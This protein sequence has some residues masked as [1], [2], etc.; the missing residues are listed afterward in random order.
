MIPRTIDGVSIPCVSLS[1]NQSLIP[2]SNATMEVLKDDALP[3]RSF[4]EISTPNGVTE[5]YRTRQPQESYTS[6]YSTIQ[7][8]HAICE[9]GDFLIQD[10]IEEEMTVHDAIVAVFNHYR[11]DK[12]QLGTFTAA[13]TVTLDCDYDN[14]LE[15]M[16]SILEQ[17]PKYYLTFDFSTSPWTVSVT[18]KSE[19]VT[20]EGRMSRNIANDTVKT[21]DKDQC[22]RVYV[23]GLP[24][25]SGREEDENAIGYM[26]ADAATIAQYG[27]IEKETGSGNLT[28]EQATRIAQAYL[29]AHKLPKRSIEID[30]DD[31]SEITG[32]S[33][34]SFVCGKKFRLA[35]PEDNLIIEDYITKVSFQD[36][37]N[38][39]VANVI[40]G[41]E[42][43]AAINFF[44]AQAS[45]TK[46]S[47][48]AKKKQ[49]KLDEAF[50]KSFAKVDETGAILE[51]A[52]MKL[53]SH[54]MIVYARDN[55]NNIGSILD[56]T[57]SEIRSEVAAGDL[58]LRSEIS[59]TASAIR[60]SVDNSLSDVHSNIIQTADQI[61]SEVNTSN[62]SVYS[63]INQ[64]ATYIQAVVSDVNNDLHSEILQTQS[65]IRSAV[66]T[67][68]SLV[69]S[70]VDQ[71]ASYIL[72]H[73]GER[74]GAKV[75]TGME[76]P[77]D[78]PENPI[79]PGDLWLDG[80]YINFWD[81]A[82]FKFVSY[83]PDDPDYDWTQLR[84]TKLK[85]WKDGEWQLAEDGTTMVEDTEFRRTKDQ[86]NLVAYNLGQFEGE[87][88]SNIARID[89]KADRIVSTVNERIADVGSNITQTAY[90]IRSEVHSANSQLYSAIEQT[91]TSI[92]SYV[93]DQI[94]DVGSEIL[95]TANQ[96]RSEVHASES[97]IYSSIDQTA[98]YIRE[99]VAS[100]ESGV[101]SSITTEANRISL[102][103]EGTGTNAKIKP[104]SIVNSINNGS[105][106]II[107]SADHINLDGY[108]K[109]TDIT[110]DL[111]KTKIS[112][113]DTL[114]VGYVS[115]GS[116]KSITLNGS[117]GSAEL[118]F[119]KMIGVIKD[120]RLTQSGNSYT[121]QKKNYNGGENDWVNVGSF[122]R[123][124][125]SW[126][127]A[128]GNGKIQVTALPQ[129]QSKVVSVSIDG[130]NTITANG[131]YTYTVDYEN[132]DGDDV[133]T[134]ATKSVS[135]NVGTDKGSNWYCTIEQSGS[136]KNCRLVKSFGASQSIP[137]TN[138]RSYRL[139]TH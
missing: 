106:S 20:A 134:G 137:F 116:G 125:S 98:T 101:R 133:S 91:A 51:Q 107:I 96:I 36:A 117:G 53:D 132:A 5:I 111:I 127:W 42:Q 4:V 84:G 120:L 72:D 126:L 25:P 60:L 80:D 88:R 34:D 7:L 104:A 3:I 75:F 102:V 73:V 105:S 97:S 49:D 114:A 50:E 135:V 108:V 22:T 99:E 63:Y 38:S 55:V 109:A 62:S 48:G 68:N 139:Y 71:T 131:T 24:K 35:I 52:G 28:E 86:I 94:N 8:D 21:D 10:A 110:A 12:W 27:I 83:D 69:Y 43:D 79:A 103:V 67:A 56:M 82:D 76:E 30:G 40:I 39:S 90:Q 100:V 77:V 66:W 11:G 122:S 57:A 54:G 2:L 26:D 112:L 136:T 23:K 41:D 16:L 93:V 59:Q 64:T 13:E 1:V 17:V 70:Y 95:Q 14:V 121:L 47:K 9:V 124:V 128:G 37:I 92:R 129:D 138:G 123:A 58:G 32:E 44:Q 31:L 118:S 18:Q 74:T 46:A 85:V 45:S 33:L 78:S 89:V 130:Q 119:A 81:D 29:D 15:T 61:R 113:I 87:L 65:M 6:G 115:V 19:T